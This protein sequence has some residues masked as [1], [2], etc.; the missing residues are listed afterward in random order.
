MLGASAIARAPEPVDLHC[1]VIQRLQGNG[2]G[3]AFTIRFSRGGPGQAPSVSGELDSE[4]QTPEAKSRAP[5]WLL[6]P[7]GNERFGTCVRR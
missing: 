3:Q 5:E 4:C 2:W 1:A 7:V 6:N